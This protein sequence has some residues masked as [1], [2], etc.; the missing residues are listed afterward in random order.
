MVHLWSHMPILGCCLKLWSVHSL[1]MSLS[2]C[3][4]QIWSVLESLFLGL[5]AL[6]WVTGQNRREDCVGLF[7]LSPPTSHYY[8][9]QVYSAMDEPVEWCLS[10]QGIG[11][12]RIPSWIFFWMPQSQRKIRGGVFAFHKA[13]FHLDET[14]NAFGHRLSLGVST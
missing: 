11:D 14:L 9:D 8:C 4:S 10:N 7:C 3:K 5:Q 1:H 6:R 12:I 13:L 2:H